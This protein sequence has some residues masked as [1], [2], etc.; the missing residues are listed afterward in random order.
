[1]PSH[2]RI[3]EHASWPIIFTLIVD[4]FGTQFTSKQHVQH[5]IAG[6]KQEYEAITTDWDSKLFCGIHLDWDYQARMVDLSMPGY[7]KGALT[8]FTHPALSHPEHQPHITTNPSTV[9]S[10]NWLIHQ[11]QPNHSLWHKILNYRNSQESFCTMR[12]LSIPLCWS[13]SAQSRHNRR[14]AWHALQQMQ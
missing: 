6:L 7:V 5:L 8:D 10:Y 9:P 14:R 13:H 11:T 12:E 2:S 1:M 4:D 3:M